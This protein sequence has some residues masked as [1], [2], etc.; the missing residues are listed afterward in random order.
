ML[1]GL[2]S[3]I[4]VGQKVPITLTFKKMGAVKVTATAVE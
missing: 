4:T 3:P 2:K 1:M